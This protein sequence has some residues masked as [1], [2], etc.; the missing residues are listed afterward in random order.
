[1]S[2][3]HARLFFVCLLAIL[4]LAGQFHLCADTNANG[5]ASHFCPFCATAG[6]AIFTPPLSMAMIP[7]LSKLETAAVAFEISVDV[8]RVTSPRAPPAIA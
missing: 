8:P 6:S 7:V 3:K 5:D 2:G 4:F 1:M